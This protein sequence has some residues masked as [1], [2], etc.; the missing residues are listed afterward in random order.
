MASATPIPTTETTEVTNTEVS[1]TP[2]TKRK[3][4]DTKSPPDMGDD[5]IIM[6]QSLNFSPDHKIRLLENV[7]SDESGA[8]AI[9]TTTDAGINSSPSEAHTHIGEPKIKRGSTRIQP[10]RVKKIYKAKRVLP[11]QN[12]RE[13]KVKPQSPTVKI[14]VIVNELLSQ[15]PEI[16]QATN[17]VTLQDLEKC[18]ESGFER[19]R[20]EFPNREEMDKSMELLSCKLKNDVATVYEQVQSNAISI[21]DQSE[22]IQAAKDQLDAVSAKLT[23]LEDEHKT[24]YQFITNKLN[25]LTATVSN[26]KK[27]AERPNASMQTVKLTE[28]NEKLQSDLDKLQAKFIESQTE[29]DKLNEKMQSINLKLDSVNADIPHSVAPNTN[30]TDPQSTPSRNKCV[31]IEGVTESANQNLYDIAIEMMDEMG[32]TLHYWEIN[33][34]ERIGRFNQN[35]A[36]PRHIRLSLV[37]DWKREVLIECKDNLFYTPNYYKVTIKPDEP[38]E[39]RVAKAKLRQA[40]NKARRQGAMI[41]LREDGTYINGIKYTTDN[42]DEIP[43]RFT[44]MKSIPNKSYLP[45]QTNPWERQRHQQQMKTSVQNRRDETSEYMDTTPSMGTTPSFDNVNGDW[46]EPGIRKI[47]GGLAFFTFR[48]FMSNFNSAPFSLNGEDNKTGEHGLQ[49]EKAWFH[50]DHNAV[51]AIRAASTPAEA[52]Q[53]GG[54]I[55][56]SQEWNLY[57]YTASD[58]VLYARYSQNPELAERLCATGSCRLI[59]ASP[60]VDWGIG[61]SIWDDLVKEGDGPGNNNFGKSTERVRARLQKEKAERRGIWAPNTR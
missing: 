50:R 35:R 43:E 26:V 11:T 31:I 55:T 49:M 46:L 58:K 45:N 28:K 8:T 20:N 44:D 18:F 24:D 12:K 39:L 10:S 2:I 17:P 14:P 19:L 1:N 61:I 33:H 22:E 30:T 57:K 38:K 3:I 52:K 51:L 6:S 13:K 34:I 37:A 47:K 7:D 53:I 25:K 15:Q 56:A 9:T 23:L 5:S 4:D 21:N 27:T 36:W 60:D 29:I 40:T 48:A 42:I 54:S 32:I 59:E 16:T 41:R